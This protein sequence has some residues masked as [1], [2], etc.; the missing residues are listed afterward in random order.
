MLEQDLFERSHA[1]HLCLLAALT[2]ES[3]FL[4][5]PPGIG[6]SLL[7]RRLKLAFQHASNFDYLMTRFSTPEELF[8]PLS[9]Q[10]LKDHGLYQ[11]LTQGY[12]PEAEIVF[13]DEIWKAGPAI[14]NTLLTAI[15]E[16][17]FRN[18]N[19]EMQIPL[20]LLI[21]ASNELPEK[22]SGLEALYDRILIRLSLGNIQQ[23]S[24]F[25]ALL[26]C[27][28]TAVESLPVDLAISDE[29]YQQWQQ[30]IMQVTLP[31]TVFELLFTLRQQLEQGIL[32]VGISDRRWKKA[33]RLL[34]ACAFFSGRNAISPLDLVLLKDCLWQAP[35]HIP[36]LENQLA[37]LLTSHGWQQQY[38]L[39]ELRTI[40]QQE[41]QRRQNLTHQQAL[42]LNV[43]KSWRGLQHKLPDHLTMD[44]LDLP[45]ETPLMLHE[46]K[47]NHIGIERQALTRWL[48]DGGEIHGK[49]NA[50]GFALPLNLRVDKQHNLLIHD[51]SLQS[52]RLL[53]PDT[54]VPALS[55]AAQQQLA[56]LEQQWWRVHQQ[57]NQ[58]Q[59]CLFIENDWLARIED[60][61]QDVLTQIKQVRAN[62]VGNT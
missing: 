23:K 1:V 35:E 58:Q 57:F 46:R 13:L 10:A 18:G 5:G 22:D 36:L 59:P 2:G 25:Y 41:W 33:V 54:S 40:E 4:L 53:L 16:R 20:R 14:L 6:K 43:Q 17:R 12:L 15:N 37:A 52:S 31:Q 9:I 26:T 21:T 3:V 39:T 7:A 47:I 45:L 49:L 11:R 44:T 19:D 62:A 28:Q 50:T 29:E 30:Q 38:L 48:A 32:T 34:R 42:T 56:D 24:H 8:G 55:D 27:Q 61:L 51:I 60:S